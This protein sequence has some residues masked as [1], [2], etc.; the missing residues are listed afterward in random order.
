VTVRRTQRH[1]AWHDASTV[2]EVGN[3]KKK[4]LVWKK[5]KSQ[6]QF[7]IHLA[8]IRKLLSLKYPTLSL[9][10]SEE[11]FRKISEVEDW[12]LKVDADD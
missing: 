6:F 1:R 3:M 8:N 11:L 7:M 12:L 9:R 10:D 4:R 5:R 2:D